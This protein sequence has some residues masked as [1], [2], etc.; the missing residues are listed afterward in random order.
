MLALAE[1]DDE[2]TLNEEENAQVEAEGEPADE[3]ALLRTDQEIPIEELKEMFEYNNG[4][5]DPPEGLCG[6]WK[7]SNF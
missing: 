3:L 4:D 2:M 6:T 1:L 5:N 7:V